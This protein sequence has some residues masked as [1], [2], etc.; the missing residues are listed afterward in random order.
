MTDNPPF[1]K[2]VAGIFAD[3]ERESL[4]KICFIFPNKRS[5]IFF[6]N[7]LNEITGS[8]SLNIRTISSLISELSQRQ[9]AS[10]LEQLFILF[11]EYRKLSKDIADFDRFIFWGDMLISD[12]NDV[13]RY[14]VDPDALFVNVH[15]FKEISSTYLTDEQ[16]EIIKRYWGEEPENDSAERF[17][18]HIDNDSKGSTKNKFLKL[19]EVLGE[20]YHAFHNRLEEQGKISSG[21]EY[22]KV[23]SAIK[24]VV[25]EK[26]L[27]FE[28]YVFVGFNVLSP[29]EIKIVSTL[30]D[31]GLADFYWDYNS[32]AFAD[33]FNRAG[34]FIEKNKQ[35]FPSKYTLPEEQITTLP[36]IEIIGVPSSMA[37]VK[38]A[39]NTLREWCED[40]SIKNT[41]N[42]VDTAVVLPD[43]SLFIGLRR[44][45]PY[46]LISNIN[47]TMGL[48]LKL[49]PIA[50]LMKIIVNMQMRMRITRG[51]PT[52]YYDDILAIINNNYINALAPD[53]AEL[54]ENVIVTN[55]HFR[56]SQEQIAEIAP[57]FAP[58]FYPLLS[59]DPSNETVYDYI[60]G[61]IELIENDCNSAD[62]KFL[63]AYKDA[64]ESVKEHCVRFDTEIKPTTFFRMI[65]KTVSG[66]KINM[67]G[68]PLKGLQMMGVL[69]TRALDFDNIIM[70]S[71]NERIF[72]RKHY[73]G[74]FIP[75][76]LRKGYGMATADF[77]E[78][79]F[80]YYFYRLISRA[81]KVK[82]IYD[83]R[84]VGT[85]TGE[86][87][88]YLTQLIYLFGDTNRV[89]SSLRVFNPLESV[90]QS[91]EIDKNNPEILAKLEKFKSHSKDKLFISA[92]A[93]NTYIS[94]PLA[95]YLKHVEGFSDDKDL[96]EFMDAGT[97]GTIV[98][99]VLQEIYCNIASRHCGIIPKEELERILKSTDITIDKLI[100]WNINKEFNKFDESRRHT[101]LE[102][103]TL[104]MGKVMKESIAA[105]L[106]A[107]IQFA[108]LTLV[109]AEKS[110]PIDLKVTVNLSVNFKLKIDRID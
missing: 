100:G 85:K 40:G 31:Y 54:I 28:K 26:R 45:I 87:S 19:W 61:I 62:L 89:Q 66:E 24:N 99:N 46:D 71:M 1:L 11:D 106:K 21:M 47:V 10:R 81:K 4:N 34:K 75:D 79:I 107:D 32:P 64:V 15:R 51:V 78:S 25:Q 94:C 41:D 95:F 74:S 6:R 53:E 2:Q 55:R 68:E 83:A 82:L 22:R 84:S 93:L 96:N 97:Y 69:E 17:W 57:T 38:L 48:P 20:L 30:R 14:L 44:S 70:L 80:A 88:R 98:H 76:A 12:F 63:K 29:A 65:E 8:A 7:Y 39:G 101:P 102:G 58:V 77:Q 91:I 86:M 90:N 60:T 3:N 110:I 67:I 92:S 72:P 104:I 49:T 5:A 16:R 50:A 23:A 27:P 37:Q 35:E 9:S 56:M 103:E 109:E 42:A 33:G 18:N 13:D 108:P 105:V 43:E 52:F 73:S 59:A 36:E